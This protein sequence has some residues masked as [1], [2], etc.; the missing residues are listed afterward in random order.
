MTAGQDGHCYYLRFLPAKMK[1]AIPTVSKRDTQCFI[2]EITN[3]Y[4]GLLYIY[5]VSQEEW[6]KLRES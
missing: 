5:K 3:F 6:T 4:A 2:R 1:T